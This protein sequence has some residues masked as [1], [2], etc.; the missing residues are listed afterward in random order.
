M[1]IA[2][3]DDA[4]FEHGRVWQCLDAK[5]IV[6]EFLFGHGAR[7]PPFIDFLPKQYLIGGK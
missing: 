2:P 7:T 3:L 6:G 5:I 1:L 4:H